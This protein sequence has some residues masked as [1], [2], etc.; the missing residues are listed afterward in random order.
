VLEKLTDDDVKDNQQQVYQKINVTAEAIMED[1]INADSD[2]S[3]IHEA[4][5]DEN[6]NSIIEN[7]GKNS[8]NEE[9]EE[10]VNQEVCKSCNFPEAIHMV[11]TLQGFLERSKDVPDYILEYHDAIHDFR[12][13]LVKTNCPEENY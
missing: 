4:T 11:R 10:Y 1:F 7:K 2:V 12:E 6:V 9:K 8:D 3:I 5:D 13:V